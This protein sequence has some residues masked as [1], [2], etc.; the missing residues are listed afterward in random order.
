MA[1]A[2]IL[3]GVLYRILPTLD[4]GISNF[5]P[6]MAVAFCGAAYFRRGWLWLVP[7]AALTLSDV[8]LNRF[9]ALH[10]GYSWSFA[11]FAA[12]TGCF[13]AAML[14]GAQVSKNRTFLAVLNGCLLS[15]ILFY[16]VTNTQSWGSDP[17]YARSFAGWWQAMTVGHPEYP[18]TLFFFRNSFVGD[19]LFTGLF[20][21][22][23]EMARLTQER[24]LKA[25]LR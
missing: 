21:G 14:I 19:L 23:M 6:L 9:Y 15:S 8:Y 20:A 17:F 22:A 5:S 16:F 13:A 1:I 11:G 18:P 7:F 3:L 24:R 4:P 10:Y 2:L 12:R 25:A